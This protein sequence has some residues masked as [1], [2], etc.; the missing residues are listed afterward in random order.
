M[1][2][3]SHDSSMR[4]ANDTG[5]LTMGGGGGVG[6]VSQPCRAGGNWNFPVTFPCLILLLMSF[7]FYTAV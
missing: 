3:K 7:L 5:K 4:Y 6:K 1:H 2:R